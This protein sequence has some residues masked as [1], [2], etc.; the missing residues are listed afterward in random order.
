MSLIDEA[1][2]RAQS[3]GEAGAVPPPDRPWSPPPMPDA[4][5]ARRLRLRRAAGI[6]LLTVAAAGAAYLYLRRP[7]SSDAASR[8]RAGASA[9]PATAAPAVV[10]PAATA[11]PV[12]VV[13]PPRPRPPPAAAARSIEAEQSGSRRAAAPVNA[14]APRRERLVSGKTY[15]GS[16]TLAEGARIELGGIVWSETEPRA[17]LNDRILGVGAYVEGFMVASIETDR[18]ELRKDSLTIFLSVQ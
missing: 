5:L 10:A 12:V 18:V 6:G 9:P 14:T 8:A 3:A 2:K 16:V 17:L 7:P 1:L 4:G 13:S 11:L 15:P